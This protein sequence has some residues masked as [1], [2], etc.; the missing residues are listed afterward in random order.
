MKTFAGR[1]GTASTKKSGFVY[2]K[3]SADDV[4]KR[5]TSRGGN[6]DSFIRDDIQMFT[7]EAKLNK[8]RF[9]PQTW[10]D[11]P[12]HYGL[13]IYVHYGIGPDNSSYLCLYKMLGEPCPICEARKQAL[14]EGDEETAKALEPTYRVLSWVINRSKEAEG[15]KLWAAPWTVDSNICAVSV[16]EDSNE[17]IYIDD[18]EEGYDVFFTRDGTGRSTKYSGEKISR[19]PSPLHKDQALAQK[20]IQFVIDN[21][22]PSCLIYKDYDHIAKV[23]AGGLAP[24]RTEKK[25]E[26]KKA[27]EKATTKMTA[28]K[29]ATKAT[30]KEEPEPEETNTEEINL[31]WEGVHEMD[32]DTLEEILTSEGVP[33]EEYTEM[34]DEEIA[35]AIC[36]MYEITK[37]EPKKEGSLKE[38]LAKMRK[39]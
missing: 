19:N 18:P 8:L 27:E 13:D 10:S 16:D 32:R 37:P 22:I 15:P 26:D 3:P 17:V 5:A 34:S 38:R 21:P 12:V 30:K 7:P 1:S 4:R 2:K 28:T 29:A 31:T 24:S 33:E 11:E 25:D 36:T 23:F 20:W 6:R 9:L 39:K 35:D 14:D